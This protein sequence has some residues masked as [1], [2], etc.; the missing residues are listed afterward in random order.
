MT[1]FRWP[2]R[3]SPV[4]YVHDGEP[5]PDRRKPTGGW[6][7]VDLSGVCAA[8]ILGFTVLG[9]LFNGW[10]S[11]NRVPAIELEQQSIGKRVTVVET[12]IDDVHRWVKYLVEKDGRGKR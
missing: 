3:G 8:I 6:S 11:I 12:K 1:W 7:F 5:V 10:D 9:M 4:M 2:K